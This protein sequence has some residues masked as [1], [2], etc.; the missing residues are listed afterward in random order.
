MGRILVLHDD[1]HSRVKEFLDPERYFE[2]VKNPRMLNVS[3]KPDPD[4]GYCN[5][6]GFK[7]GIVI[8]KLGKRLYVP[9][10]CILRDILREHAFRGC[11]KCKGEGVIGWSEETKQWGFCACIVRSGR[12]LH[13]TLQKMLTPRN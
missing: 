13:P 2:M 6:L 8:E 7:G 1:M 11:P 4:C 12:P 3:N 9:C 5:G 10:V